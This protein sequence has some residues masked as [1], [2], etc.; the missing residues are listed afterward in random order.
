M[1]VGPSYATE[2]VRILPDSVSF[3]AALLVEFPER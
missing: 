2:T 1:A 3:V